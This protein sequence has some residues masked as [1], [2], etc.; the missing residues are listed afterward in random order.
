MQKKKRATKAQTKWDWDSRGAHFSQITVSFHATALKGKW[1]ALLASLPLKRAPLEKGER[2]ADAIGTLLTHP[3]LAGSPMANLYVRSVP[4]KQANT[5]QSHWELCWRRAPSYPPP[6]NLVDHSS[7]LG[8]LDGAL[9]TISS[10]WPSKTALKLETSAFLC[11]DPKQ[12]SLIDKVAA[13]QPKTI[14]LSGKPTRSLKA[15]SINWIL[16]EGNHDSYVTFGCS[17]SGSPIT[18]SWNGEIAAK[19]TQNL[20]AKLEDEIW[21][22]LLPLMVEKQG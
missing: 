16:T 4:V 7:Q 21:E 10:A 13:A 12:Y 14:R 18:V 9:R 1:E 6:D 17:E 15:D 8:G 19:F 20:F 2:F 5:E 22:A 3:W 11:V